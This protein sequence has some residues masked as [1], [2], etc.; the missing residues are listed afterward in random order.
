MLSEENFNE[1]EREFLYTAI[2]NTGSKE[3]YIDEWELAEEDKD[4]YLNR[5]DIYVQKPFDLQNLLHWVKI[6]FTVKGYPCNELDETDFESFA[7]EINPVLRVFSMDNVKRFEDKF[8]S[9]WWKKKCTHQ[10]DMK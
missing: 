2:E 7:F 1:E 3:Y 10:S 9:E 4:I 6:Y 8:G 5:A